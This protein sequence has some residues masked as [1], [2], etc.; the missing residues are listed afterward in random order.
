[1]TG[2]GQTRVFSTEQ[3]LCCVVIRDHPLE[4]LLHVLADNYLQSDVML[5]REILNRGFAVNMTATELSITKVLCVNSVNHNN[6][7]ALQSDLTAIATDVIGTDKSRLL[8]TLNPFSEYFIT[9]LPTTRVNTGELKI[10]LIDPNRT[11]Y[12]GDRIGCL[13]TKVALCATV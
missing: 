3:I 13:W 9:G 11:V 8:Q 4:V 7:N 1:M 10:K 12:S 5:G 6:D 2:I